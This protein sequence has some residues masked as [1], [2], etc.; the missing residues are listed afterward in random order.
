MAA[1]KALV[2]QRINSIPEYVELF[3]V[4]YGP[5]VKI[6]FERIAGVIGVFERTLV[7][8]SRF[9]AYL[10][11]NDKALTKDEKA[12]L[13]L[14][15]DK[16]CTACHNGIAMGGTMQ[17]FQVAKEYKF[18]QLGGFKGDAN[19]MVKAPTLRNITE[20]AP[21][22]HNG[23]IWNLTDAI[24]EMGSVQLGITI[25]DKEAK[26]IATFLKSVEGEKPVIVYPALPASTAT[27]EKPTFN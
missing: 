7:T 24:K 18:A 27:T 23:A 6:D 13:K 2:E 15:I 26:S 25:S 20:T 16:G 8:P 1:P 4:A 3:K 22:F 14:F 17:P 19:G 9:D 5:N 11:G 10:E 21:Y 12:G